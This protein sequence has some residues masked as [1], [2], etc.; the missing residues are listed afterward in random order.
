MSPAKSVTRDNRQNPEYRVVA[1]IRKLW[2]D[3]N[4]AAGKSWP[5]QQQHIG[6]QFGLY[7]VL[8]PL[9]FLRS[10]SLASLFTCLFIFD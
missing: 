4:C 7:R 8:A 2:T 6:F 3:K 1:A 10:V 5:N 9:S